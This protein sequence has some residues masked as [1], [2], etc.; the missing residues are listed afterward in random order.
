MTLFLALTVELHPFI[1]E[2]F[3]INRLQHLGISLLVATTLLMQ[4]PTQAQT[5]IYQR[6]SGS[7]HSDRYDHS[8]RTYPGYRRS[9]T[10][11][12][13]DIENSTLVNPVIIDS[14]IEDSTLVNPVIVT[15]PSRA[16]VIQQQPSPTRRAS[17]MS[18]ASLRLA[19]Q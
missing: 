11:I 5:V 17:C 10:V 16:T 15:P 19:C 1:L 4:G 8:G 18:F 14:D 12:R 6:G 7:V 2:N 9:G 3:M 13:G